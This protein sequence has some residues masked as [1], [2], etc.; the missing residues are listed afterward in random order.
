MTNE[1]LQLSTESI[2]QFCQQ[3]QVKELS[4]FGSAVRGELRP[5]S[6]MDFLVEFEPEARIGLLALARMTRELSSLLGREVDLVPKAG[7]KS[8]IRDQVLAEAEVLFAQ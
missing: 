3:N 5:D 1:V 4:L 2:A 7:L 6:D 8:C